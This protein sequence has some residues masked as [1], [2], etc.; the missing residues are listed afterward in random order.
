MNNLQTLSHNKI[1][2]KSTEWDLVLKELENENIKLMSYDKTLLEQ[3]DWNEK[4]VLDYGAG[5]G[6]LAEVMKK[7]GAEVKVY[8][9]SFEMR[10]RS[11]QRIGRENIYDSIA[12][13]PKNHFDVIVCNLVLCIVPEDE[14]Q[15]IISNIRMMLKSGGTAFMGF[16]NP[17]IYNV[18]ESNLDFR[19]F[20]AHPYE[21]NHCYR[22]IK[23]EGLYEILEHHRPIDWYA[24]LVY[25]SG[26]VLLDIV[27]TPE[28]EIRR[29]KIND[30]I[31]L[32]LTKSAI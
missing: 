21:S 5:P 17:K 25:S 1:V 20:S 32:K 7:Q 22:K 18:P 28:Y 10:Q 13:I 16:C 3:M 19:Y 27:L 2:N 12:D 15:N 30:F 9:T 8:D 26:L 24:K 23:K 14:A 6:V 29:N 31:I 11:G 4:K